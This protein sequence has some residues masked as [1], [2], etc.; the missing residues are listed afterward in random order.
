MRVL[1]EAKT[2][3]GALRK[4]AKKDI[5]VKHLSVEFSVQKAE[6]IESDSMKR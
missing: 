4:Y 3:Q 6:A 5:E 2:L 1:H